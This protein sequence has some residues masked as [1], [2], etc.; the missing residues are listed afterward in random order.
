[1]FLEHALS[2]KFI[3]NILYLNEFIKGVSKKKKNV[4]GL[5][6]AAMAS[7]GLQNWSEV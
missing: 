4:G 1:M 2:A 6:M 5:D 7:S 3:Q